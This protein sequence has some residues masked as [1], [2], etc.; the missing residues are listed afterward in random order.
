M[1]LKWTLN[2]QGERMWTEFICVKG[3][4]ASGLYL[5]VKNLQVL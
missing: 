3:G 4:P 5:T 1:I 2:V